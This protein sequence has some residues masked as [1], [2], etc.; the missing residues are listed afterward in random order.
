MIEEPYIAFLSIFLTITIDSH[1]SVTD[2]LYKLLYC[3][4]AMTVLLP[5]FF[6]QPALVGH[7]FLEEVNV[8]ERR[9][10]TSLR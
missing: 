6:G 2:H 8:Y 9:L 7:Y 3:R 5:R 4:R 1:N 10:H